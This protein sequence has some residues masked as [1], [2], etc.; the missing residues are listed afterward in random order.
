ME[1]AG[2][3]LSQVMKA[4]CD[5]VCEELVSKVDKKKEDVRYCAR[6]KWEEAS[7]ELRASLEGAGKVSQIAVQSLK[8]KT[9]HDFQTTEERMVAWKRLWKDCL[10]HAKPVL[11]I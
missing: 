9:E 6:Q 11:G 2:A 7:Q 10:N 5:G 3:A 4:H 1:R 8:V